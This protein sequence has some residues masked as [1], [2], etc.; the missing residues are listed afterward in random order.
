ML[1][2]LNFV[3]VTVCVLLYMASLSISDRLFQKV[4]GRIFDLQ[5]TPADIRIFT[6]LT[7]IIIMLFTL[8]QAVKAFD[9]AFLIHHLRINKTSGS[10]IYFNVHFLNPIFTNGGGG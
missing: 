1:A 9:Q 6:L 7:Y 3:P 2:P 8:T 4:L 5:M 10:N